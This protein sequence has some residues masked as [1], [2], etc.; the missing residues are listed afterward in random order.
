MPDLFLRCE[1]GGL[2]FVGEGDGGPKLP[3]TEWVRVWRGWL[4]YTMPAKFIYLPDRWSRQDGVQAVL[5]RVLDR[6]RT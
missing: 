6:E 3:V 5:Q 1:D 4:V 2:L